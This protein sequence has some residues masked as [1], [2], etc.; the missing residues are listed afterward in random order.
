MIINP[1]KS[2]AV[3][4]TR[5]RVTEPLNYSLRDPVSL[6]ASS[7]KY[8]GL[9]LHSNLSW[10]LQVKYMVKETWKTLHFTMRIL[11][12]GNS[13][14]KSFAYTSVVRPILEY[15]VTCRDPYERTDKCARPGAEHSS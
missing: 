11:K 12:K 6:V 14:T 5:A 13:N 1:A 2:K 7:C 10:A 4:F 15:G 8:L 9:I 3:C